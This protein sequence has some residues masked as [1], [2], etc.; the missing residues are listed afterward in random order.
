MPSKSTTINELSA[1][2]S[3]YQASSEKRDV[4]VPLFWVLLI[5]HCILWWLVPTLTEK[6]LPLDTIEM[7]HWGQEWQLGYYKHPPLPAWLPHLFTQLF[8]NH[9]W[10]V[11]GMGQLI[12]AISFWAIWQLGRRLLSPWAA[13]CSVAV[14]AGCY[15][16]NWLLSMVNHN[17]VARPFWALSVLFFYDAIKKNRVYHWIGLGFFL[18]LSVYS[19]YDVAF[20]M[21]GFGFVMLYNQN[22]RRCFASKGPYIA[23]ITLLALISPHLWWMLQSDASPLAFQLKRSGVDKHWYDHIIQPFLFS[24]GQTVMLIPVMFLVLPM[25]RWP[26]KFRKRANEELIG[27]DVLIGAVVVPPLLLMLF[28]M[29]TGGKIKTHW[30]AQFWNYLGVLL[31]F[32]FQTKLNVKFPKLV[33]RRAVYVSL[34]FVFAFCI[35][36][37]IKPHKRY[38]HFPGKELAEAVQSA[39]KKEHSKPLPVVAAGNWWW[40]AANATFYNEDRPATFYLYEPRHSP[41]MTF[42]HL[43]ETGGIIIYGMEDGDTLASV[44]KK[45]VDKYGAIG[46]IEEVQ[47]GYIKHAGT[48]PAR[49]VI[50]VQEP[51]SQTGRIA[52][53]SKD[54]VLQ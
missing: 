38:V 20:L 14:L 2:L 15:H 45:H 28:S 10:V 25:L 53:K 46:S 54:A 37:Y 42:D 35:R 13:L 30:S 52:K 29:I 43:K 44:K 31:L 19:K 9:S 18:A 47:L 36:D 51:N 8:G 32:L 16:F 5:G 4:T 22:A 3:S 39:W 33:L 48:P 7:L 50:M 40:G 21:V 41:W 11:Y 26:L 24:V 6:N 1:P 49:F 17:T 34:V 27:R 23:A 12:A